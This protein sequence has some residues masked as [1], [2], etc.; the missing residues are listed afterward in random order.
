MESIL[1]SF[2][3]NI[4]SFSELLHATN[5]V[6]AG[7]AALAAQVAETPYKFVPNDLDIWVHSDFFAPHMVLAPPENPA[8]AVRHGYQFLF[9][10]FLKQHGYVEVD[11]PVQSDAEYTSN[12]VFAILRCIQR[13]Q[14]S[15]SGRVVQVMHCK[16]PVENLLDS[17][18]LSVAQTWWVPSLHPQ[19]REGFLYSADREAAKVGLMYLLRDCTTEREKARIK[20]Y[21]ERGF[22]LV[23]REA[24]RLHILA[25]VA[26][27]PAYHQ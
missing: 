17:F 15:A 2:H 12:P 3:L 22:R 25:Q 24:V 9:R 11:R 16:V 21:E 13:F 8:V 23:E 5:A 19:H 7:S 18:D 26:E 20:K 6:V 10:Y 4:H 1:N 27:Q 14:H